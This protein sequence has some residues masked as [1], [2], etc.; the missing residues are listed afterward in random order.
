MSK[1]EHLL[2]ELGTEE[3]P[4]KDLSR[5][6]TS[7]CGQIE[8]GIK[9]AELNYDS[10]KWFA[11]PRRLAVKVD[12]LQ[13]EQAS[14]Q[15]QRRGPAVKAAYDA[16]GN[17]SKA[18]QGFA[19][20]CQTTVDQLETLETDKGQWLAY[21][22]NV[23]GRHA[24]DLIPTIIQTSLNKLPIAKRMR[25]GNNTVEFV[26]P[27]QWSVLL[28]GKEVIDAEILGTQTSNVT[29][30]HR[31]HAPEAMSIINSDDYE[32]L[33]K[34]PGKVIADYSQRKQIILEQIKT[35]ANSINGEAIIDSGLL[36]EVTSIN[37]WPVAVVGSFAEE[38]LALPKEALI[39][40]MQDH[41]KYFPVLNSNGD[42]L[43]N[44][45]TFANIESKNIDVVRKGNERVLSP[46]L[47]DAQFFWQQD[48]KKS[49]ADYQ[50]SLENLLYQKQLG[51][52]AE[53]SSRVAELSKILANALA[54][55]TDL[56]ERAAHLAKCDLLTDMVGEFPNLQGIIGFYYAKQSGEPEEVAI[57]I[58]EQYMPR[59]S[60]DSLPETKTGQI[61]S[62]A[63]KIETIVGI[64]SIGQIPTGDKD[65]FAL[66]RAAL[67]AVRIIIECDLD[68]DLSN[69]ITSACTLYKHEFNQTECHDNVFDFIMERLRGYY[70]DNGI[71]TLTF[72]SVLATKPTQPLDFASRIKAVIAFQA[73]SEAKDLASA[74]KRISNILKKQSSP[75]DDAINEELLIE[76][77][78]KTLSKT[79]NSIKTSLKPLFEAKDYQTA[80]SKLAT[81][82]DPIDAFFDHVM[83]MAE[84][85]ALKNNRLSLLQSVNKLFL[86]IAD[87]SKLQQ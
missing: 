69:I 35:S 3:L 23:E 21:T 19:Q 53:K 85:D 32:S 67:G 47:K 54:I 18:A 70:Q 1:T 87:I 65:P 16:D 48:T 9:E 22:I 28:L 71:D 63:E 5:L 73:L 56:V 62:L 79:L 81:L 31:F 25:W 17:P 52:M 20:S 15:E 46:R 74:N 66:K 27:V 55:N 26:R 59:F 72:E 84:D 30:G 41:Q 29:Y 37:E 80:L 50:A 75:I 42:L 38:F 4:P 45:I 6:A 44:F 40:S 83:V 57:A 77:A 78:E 2:F 86:H 12:N 33:L 7:L 60:G 76:D 43:P 14:K 24:K 36:D 13:I 58:N 49:L 51:S 10:I 39:Y 61:V 34:S 68:I 82:R 8:S 64:F 11:T